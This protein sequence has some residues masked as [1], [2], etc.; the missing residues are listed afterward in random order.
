[1]RHE[2]VERGFVESL[3]GESLFDGLAEIE[4][5]HLED[6]A[7][8]HLDRHVGLRVGESLRHAGSAIQHVLVSPVR[9][10]MRGQDS[11]LRVRLQHHRSRTIC[12]DDRGRAVSPIR[13]ARERLGADDERAAR[14]PRLDEFVG[15]RQGVHKAGARRLNAEGRTT[16]TAEPLLQQHSAV[17]KHQIRRRRSKGDEVDVPGTNAR[18]FDGAPRRL[19][20]KVNGGLPVSCNMPTLNAGAVANPL[21]RGVHHPLQIEVRQN[22]LWQVRTGSRDARIH[23][24][25]SCGACVPWAP[26]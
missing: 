4:D 18:G 17:G 3:R 12:K 2:P 1:M 8:H 9:M 14:L 25:L 13:D 24:H 20:A 23:G 19:L 15:N 6:F 10:Q 26:S 16:A 7:A 21:I 11:R 5:R 22:L